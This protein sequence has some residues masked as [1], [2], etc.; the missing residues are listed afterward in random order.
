MDNLTHSLFALTLARTPLGRAGR[1]TTAALLLASNVP[2]ADALSLAGGQATYLQWHRGPTH[3]LLGAPLLGVLTAAAVWYGR[4]WIDQRRRARGL[5]APA[6]PDAS[7]GMLVA[8]SILGAIFHVLMD[9]PTTYGTRLLSPFVWR[10]YSADWLPIVDVY[11]LMVLVAG[12][13]VGWLSPAS[14]R[15][16]A[17]T[18]LVLMCVNYGAHAATHHQA[19]AMAPRLFGPVLPPACDAGAPLSGS[20]LEAWPRTDT[21][22][23]APGA[24]ACLAEFAAMPTFTSPFRWRVIA[25]LSNA[26]EVHDVDLLDERF[27]QPASEREVFWR[28]AVRV[29]DVWTPAAVDA[30]RTRSGRIFLGFSRFPATRAFVTPEGDATV[31]WN[32]IRFAGG[33]FSL[34][35]PRRPDPFTVVVR[36]GADGRV[37][38]ER[39]GFQ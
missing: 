23:P 32:D 11:L 10:W 28:T 6:A 20:W 14:R 3:G 38:S 2:D 15:R 12:L 35:E 18:A 22:A 30:A 33:V 19:L 31:R 34:N 17:A 1:G 9:L 24:R 8:V 21:R 13:I 5:P 39:L 27:Q 25:R 37:T 36:L 16:S 4:Q 7:F 26:Y 29:P